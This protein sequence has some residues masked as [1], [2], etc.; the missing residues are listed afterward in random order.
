MLAFLFL[1]S[2]SLLHLSFSSD[3]PFCR[4]TCLKCYV[5]VS[6]NAGYSY[7]SS[8]RSSS[9]P[10]D[11]SCGC[12]G[13]TNCQVRKVQLS[14]QAAAT[15]GSSNS[16]STPASDR[17]CGSTVLTPEQQ[18]VVNT[19]YLKRRDPSLTCYQFTLQS[20]WLKGAT[21]HTDDEPFLDYCIS[22]LLHQLIVLKSRDKCIVGMLTNL[23]RM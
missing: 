18:I 21:N 3:R 10:L 15:N 14:S 2:L 7:V 22:M 20:G 13:H 8:S 5:K 12:Y 23:C 6:K 17:V 9:F 4:A 11:G 19:Y 16:A 1:F